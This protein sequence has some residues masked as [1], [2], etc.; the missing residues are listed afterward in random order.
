MA[1]YRHPLGDY[2]QYYINN[3]VK[4]EEW[5]HLCQN[6][7]YGQLD[8]KVKSGLPVYAMS[9]GVITEVSSGNFKEG[10]GY[11]VKIKTNRKDSRNKEFYNRYFLLE[12]LG[13]TTAEIFGVKSGKGTYSGQQ[14]IKKTS[15]KISAG[16]LIGYTGK[17]GLHI[18]F[19][20]EEENFD[21]IKTVPVAEGITGYTGKVCDINGQPTEQDI[22][23]ILSNMVCTQTPIQKFSSSTEVAFAE[24][25]NS[26]AVYAYF[27][28]TMTE[29]WAGPYPS[30]LSILNSP[31][32]AIRYATAICSR[33]LN[34]EFFSG[35]AYAKLLR[36]KMIG[37]MWHLSSVST[38]LEWFKNI[39]PYQFEG[40]DKWLAKTFT[41]K[42]LTYAQMVYKN[43]VEPG[44]YGEQYF[45]NNGRIPSEYADKF[46]ELI[47]YGWSQI[48]I[49]NLS[50]IPSSYKPLA[51]CINFDVDTGQ[52]HGETGGAGNY[53]LYRQQSKDMSG[54][55]SKCFE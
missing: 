1:D 16:T 23:P 18:D 50:P 5:P 30:T 37:E 31:N 44:L 38:A 8:W 15:K 22:S 12:G 47:Y 35:V 46:K 21:S 54:F 49:Y 42:D 45:N 17:E 27:N 3:Q 55:R 41:E 19:C 25:M 51:F 9:D 48:P 39:N 34:F 2:A 4:T 28:Q 14:S 10:K 40:K 33:E 13:E 26:D 29:R 32:S 52:D 24:N 11:C 53:L 43:L 7:G 6:N 20:Y 36:A